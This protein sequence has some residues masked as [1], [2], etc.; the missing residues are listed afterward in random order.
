MGGY[1]VVPAQRRDCLPEAMRASLGVTDDP[2]DFIVWTDDEYGDDGDRETPPVPVSRIPDAHSARLLLAALSASRRGDGRRGV[3]NSERPFAEDIFAALPGDD[4]LMVSA[5]TT[6]DGLAALDADLVYLMLHGDFV[7]GSRFWG[8]GP[9]GNIEAVNVNSIPDD[10][11]RVVFTGC[12][13][14]ALTVDQPAHRTLLP[15]P[16]AVN[17]SIALRFLEAGATAFVG[18]TGAHY[19]PREKPYR[20]F[21][22]PMHEAFW[23]GLGGGQ[24]PA[25]ALL[26]A[27]AEYVRDFPHGMRSE[28]Q[29]AIEYKT[30]HQYTCLG[31]GW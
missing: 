16:K 7:D 5:P 27:K 15:A 21:G 19:S 18:C 3:R 6:F 4:A 1:D 14:G 30:L 25:E 13:W 28:A 24:A 17:A 9:A 23:R 11:P 2:D 22:G 29:H 26:A 20:Y 31:L 10:G 8:E 12:C